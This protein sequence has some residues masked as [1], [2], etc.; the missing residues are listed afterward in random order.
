MPEDTSDQLEITKLDDLS[1]CTE[2]LIYSLAGRLPKWRISIQFCNSNCN[3]AQPPYS[4][5]K[6]AKLIIEIL[7]CSAFHCDKLY[8]NENI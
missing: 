6:A 7:N 5:S 8:N 1:S 3:L 2:C 4:D